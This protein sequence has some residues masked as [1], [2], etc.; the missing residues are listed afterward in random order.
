MKIGYENLLIHTTWFMK[1]MTSLPQ[2][3]LRK[4]SFN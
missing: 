3:I 4:S 2:N 1:I